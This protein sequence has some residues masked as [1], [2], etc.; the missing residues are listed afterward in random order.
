MNTMTVVAYAQISLS[1]L[2]I[3]G[4]F[5]LLLLFLL[6]WVSPPL[7]WKELLGQLMAVLTAGVML[8]LQFW[9]LRQRP[10]DAGEE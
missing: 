8:I 6:G 5:G 3:T 9:F 2:F 1:A 10:K 4:Y 7:A